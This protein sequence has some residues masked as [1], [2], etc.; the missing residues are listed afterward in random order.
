MRC[1][2]LQVKKIDK[3]QNLEKVDFVP[4]TFKGA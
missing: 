2:M 1:A 3:T 4:F